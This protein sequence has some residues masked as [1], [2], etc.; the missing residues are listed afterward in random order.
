MNYKEFCQQNEIKTSNTLDIRTYIQHTHMVDKRG[1]LFCSVHTAMVVIRPAPS[2]DTNS[3]S[4]CTMTRMQ[5][6]YYITTGC[7]ADEY[8]Y[9]HKF[10]RKAFLV[11]KSRRSTGD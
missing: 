10:L 8:L 4:T 5:N 11:V 6:L 9:V 1:E 3:Y 2:L 7:S